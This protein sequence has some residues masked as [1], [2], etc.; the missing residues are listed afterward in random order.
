MQEILD[1]VKHDETSRFDVTSDG[2]LK[3]KD[4]R[5]VIANDTELRNEILDE[6][7]Q[8]KY[9]IHPGSTKMYRELKK[10]W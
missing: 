4:G 8:T 2:V 3:T 5:V 7:H 1:E 9:T 10:F 6:A